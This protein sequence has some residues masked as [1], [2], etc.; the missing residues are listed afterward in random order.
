M[1]GCW[2]LNQHLSFGLGF[3]TPSPCLLLSH[4]M[5]QCDWLLKLRENPL[6]AG[7]LRRERRSLILS[8]PVAHDKL[9]AVSEASSS[10]GNTGGWGVSNRKVGGVP[11]E[12]E[13]HPNHR[14]G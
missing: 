1:E 13:H 12:T 11:V 9:Q 2:D 14:V 5:K 10:Q 3:Q 4:N 6:F 8:R 7:A